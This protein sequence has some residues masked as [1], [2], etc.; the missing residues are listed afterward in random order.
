MRLG[1]VLANLSPP[2]IKNVEITISTLSFILPIHIPRPVLDRGK[3]NLLN[4]SI[5]IP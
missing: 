5:R 4:F 1:V 2:L 3:I